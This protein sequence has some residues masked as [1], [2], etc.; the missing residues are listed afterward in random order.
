MQIDFSKMSTILFSVLVMFT[1]FQVKKKPFNYHLSNTLEVTGMAVLMYDLVSILS[2][3]T[4]SSSNT[5]SNDKMVI[6][7]VLVLLVNLVYVFLLVVAVLFGTTQLVLPDKWKKDLKWIEKL[8]GISGGDIQTS[9][10][11]LVQSVDATFST[12]ITPSEEQG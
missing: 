9:K 8:L 5:T 4:L 1:F 11:F 6:M 10:V 12:K 7:Q 3:N 2:A